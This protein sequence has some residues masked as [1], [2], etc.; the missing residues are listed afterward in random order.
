[1]LEAD[2]LKHVMQLDIHAEVVRVELEL[3]AGSDAGIFVDIQRQGGDP[4][5]DGDAPMPVGFRS[6]V[7]RDQGRLPWTA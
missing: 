2:S 1:M 3:V 4:A 7:E 5:L 6:A